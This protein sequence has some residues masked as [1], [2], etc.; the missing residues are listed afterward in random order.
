MPYS[1]DQRWLLDFGSYYEEEAGI[2]LFEVWNRVVK[3]QIQLLEANK[4]SDVILFRNIWNEIIRLKRQITPFVSK[5][6][7]L[8]TLANAFDNIQ[9]KSGFDVS[10]PCQYLCFVF[11]FS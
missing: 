11:P 10:P 6:G 3:L 1:Q 7:L 9:N 4:D 8:F 5:D 2:R